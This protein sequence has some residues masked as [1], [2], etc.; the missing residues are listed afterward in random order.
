MS[1]KPTYEQLQ[2]QLNH[3]EQELAACRQGRPS[4]EL[5]YRQ[6]VDSLGH[7]VVVTSL[8]GV[9]TYWS[10]GAEVLYGW[11]GEE[12]VGQLVTHVFPSSLTTETESRI[13]EALARGESWSG[14]II[15]CR[16][17]GSTFPAHVTD[18]PLLDQSGALQGLIGVSYD[19]SQ[20][21]DAEAKVI[22]LNNELIQT[23]ESITDAFF[24]LD[25]ELVV[26]YFNAAAERLLARRREDVLGR[27]LFD[28]F[29]EAKG[30][31][32]EINYTRA[33]RENVPI[34]F[35]T[36][37]E[38]E[39]YRNWF[40]VSVY[41]A[42]KGICVYFRVITER[43]LQE[44]ELREKTEE[45]LV[46]NEEFTTINEELRQRN[47]EYIALNQDYAA[48]IDELQKKSDQVRGLL[49]S[50][51]TSEREKR[52]ILNATNDL[53]ALQDLNHRLIWVNEAAAKS[54]GKNEVELVGRHCY[55]VWNERQIPCES[56]PVSE[57]MKTGKPATGQMMTPDGRFWELDGYPVFD[58]ENRITGFV[59][60]GRDVTQ[61]RQAEYALRVSEEK[62][63]AL[64]D[65]A[66]LSYQSLNEEGC[67]IDVNPK[68]L[69]TLGYQREE[70]IGQWFGNF[71]HPDYV[72][73]FRI[74]FPAFKKR[75][76]VSD[77]QF[78]MRHKN[79]QYI[80]VSFEGCIGYTPE[81]KFRQTYCVFKD[82]TAQKQAEEN[83]KK[84][85]WL[86][87]P[88]CIADNNFVPVYGDV[89]LH[90]TC[91]TILDAV[92]AQTLQSIMSEYLHL[93]GTSSAVYEL[94][95][96]YAAGIFSSE[97]CRFL[98]RASFERCNTDDCQQA[99]HSG[100]WHCHES[101]WHDASLRAIESAGPVDVECHGGLH[102]YAVPILCCGNVIG[103]INF[104]YG[105][106]PHEPEKIA[107]IA[108]KYGVEKDD[109]HALSA[110][111]KTRPPFIIAL[112]RHRLAEA[113]KFIGL[114]VEN[115]ANTLKIKESEARYKKISSLSSD[116]SYSLLV[117]EDGTITNEWHFG[118][119]A[120]ITGYDPVEIWE[121]NLVER[122]IHPE[123]LPK[124][125]ERM[126]R[127]LQGETVVSEMRIVTAEGETRWILDKGEPEWDQT[128]RRVVRI[129]GS[130]RDITER[131]LA[132][133]ALRESEEQLQRMFSVVPD[134]ISVHNADMDIVYSNWK[135]FGEVAPEKRIP[136]AKCYK[137]YRNHD[138]ICPDCHACR[139]L[140]T[141]EPYQE[142]V[143]LPDGTWVDLRVIPLP[144]DNG[145][146]PLFMEWVRDI[147]A[148][149]RA[150]QA[151]RASEEP[152]RFIVQ[153]IQE[154][155]YAI[156]SQGIFTFVG[157][158]F[159]RIFGLTPDI[160]I[161]GSLAQLVDM[162]GLSPD[163]SEIIFKDF[164]TALKDRLSSVQYEFEVLLQG[165]THCFETVEQLLYD[166]A[167]VYLGSIGV[168]RDITERRLAVQALSESEEKFRTL[169]ENQG[170][171]V[172]ITDENDVFVFAN[173]V[174]EE[175]FGVPQNG[176]TGRS[177][178]DFIGADNVL[179]L[180]R[181][182]N[183]RRKGQ[184]S[185]YELDIRTPSGN[186]RS[187]L[188]TVTPRFDPNG[189]FTGS[190]GVFR[191]VTERKKAEEALKVSEARFQ[192]IARQLPGALY[193]FKIDPQ[194][195]RSV[196]FVSKSAEKL[197]ERPV[198]EL[199][200]SALLFADVHP[201]DLPGFLETIEF[202][203][204]HLSSW[205][206]EFR[207]VLGQGVKWL[208]GRSEPQRFED[209]SVLW[210]GILLDITEQKDAED[211]IRRARDE[212]QRSESRY[213][214]LFE[215]ITSG[216][217]LHRMICDEAGKATDYVFISVNPAFEQLTGLKAENMIGRTVREVLP[218]IEPY[219]IERYGEAAKTGIPARFEDYF[220]ELD[221]YYDVL[222]FSPEK[223][224][225]AVLF[226]D[227]S[228][229]KRYE[230]E[231]LEAKEK[232]EESN[233]LKTA[234]LNNI[235]HEFRTPMNGILGFTQLAFQSGTPPEKQE[236]YALRVHES[237]YRLLD[238]VT[239]TIEMSQVQSR[240]V[241]VYPR[242][243]NLK[244]ILDQVMHELG[245]VARSKKLSLS[246]HLDRECTAAELIIDRHKVYRTLRHLV[247]N[248]IKFTTR[249]EV[250]IVCKMLT[251]YEMSFSVRDTGIGISEEM[252]K[253]IFEPFRQVETGISRNYGGNGIGLSLAKAYVELL[254]GRIWLESQVNRGTMVTFT[255]PVK[256]VDNQPE[257]SR[258][259]A[260]PGNDWT[261]K[262]ILIAEDMEVN[263]F[264]FEEVLNETK[265]TLLY[266]KN[267]AEVID[268][269][270]KNAQIDLILMDIKMPDLDGFE[271]TKLLKEFRSDIP[272]IAQTAYALED[273]KERIAAGGFDA[274]IAKPFSKAELFALMRKLLK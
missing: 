159:E 100:Q 17:D 12:V 75:G 249:G 41:P 222:A 237:C 238:I 136:G 189:H 218:G 61:K 49:L 112:A 78:R 170:E 132:S 63:R 201:D 154:F 166:D 227:V 219:W 206:Y 193:Q 244:E 188:I 115:S 149:K 8:N 123:D 264:Y 190:F 5:E 182:N 215:N 6:M 10:R 270:R 139:V 133:Q 226:S 148:S 71:L 121:K 27:P 114:L 72:E 70:V 42:Q 221:R 269:C 261:G 199:M 129:V 106:P 23:L 268:F 212:V 31:V 187:L 214:L 113:A 258:E 208:S 185:T 184:K 57:A 88:A 65:N 236:L 18:T 98:D 83:L 220:R 120:K 211:E 155:I 79:G 54:V 144:D 181:E 24:S 209:G 7:A 186:K 161:G 168:V 241:E 150:E 151:L 192:T 116:Y 175:I 34:S 2:Q 124:A 40:D 162:L 3:L 256:M 235:S 207:I 126:K 274:Y 21:L 245:D 14:M 80:D 16:K 37:F 39:P 91:R 92:G 19:M 140:E 62:F 44:N 228:F 255:I 271:T 30:S 250:E 146:V 73:H 198:E 252:Q 169:I 9:I 76:Y 131:K 38:T 95:G 178:H 59:E 51:Q 253:L 105:N 234:F 138:A 179:V 119:F 173:P 69:S 266:A 66:P 32:F 247:D 58:P 272:V 35:E 43:K 243:T 55:E 177:L 22:S 74:N 232:A 180:Q 142:E 251:P 230:L 46:Q 81:G 153:N 156:D 202:S 223:D 127:Q 93:L 94:N 118:A 157:G 67:F 90:N 64:Y 248:A 260:D 60:V 263:S 167:D 176:L 104:G 85:E 101:C 194:G 141:K 217:A 213:R 87:D 204:R 103:A 102:I 137:T 86:L 158:N 257:T 216:F 259:T 231:L 15:L 164:E 191:D 147:T 130:A 233:R 195:I 197:F 117:H 145:N 262:V 225:F 28:S 111:Y 99:I 242:P 143:A 210:N 50:L 122:L 205:V 128:G 171:G 25:T 11:K 239:D 203:Y 163:I 125:A 108:A 165:K 48:T 84:I 134:M 20:Q 96:D 33:L 47:E 1:N 196:P 68:W 36:F 107:E 254:G 56:C 246:L 110:K 89:T 172:G 97:W 174:A 4:G 26:T 200:D 224:H 265:A 29:P 13:M 53:V 273:D 160:M 267:G 152:V 135:G 183:L 240:Q 52:L 82:I 45:I 229:K 77:V 109:L